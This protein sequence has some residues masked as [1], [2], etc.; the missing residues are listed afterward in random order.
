[1]SRLVAGPQQAGS[2]QEPQATVTAASVLLSVFIHA[3]LLQRKLNAVHFL[4]GD[5][6]RKKS[7]YCL[8]SL[9]LQEEM[10]PCIPKT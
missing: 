4:L 7:K 3:A 6:R 10:K 5:R 2:S 9:S 8:P 1:L